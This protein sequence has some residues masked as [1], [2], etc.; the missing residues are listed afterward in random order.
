VLSGGSLRLA[1]TGSTM[2]TDVLEGHRAVPIESAT[3]TRADVVRIGELEVP[4]AQIIEALRKKHPRFEWPAPVNESDAAPLAAATADELPT[5]PVEAATTPQLTL[6]DC[7]V[8]GSATPQLKRVKLFQWLVFLVVFYWVRTVVYTACPG[9]MRKALVKRT[10]LNLVPGNLAW[11]LIVLPVHGLAFFRSFAA[12]P[13]SGLVEEIGGL[14]TT[15]R[16][17]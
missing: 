8:C 4:V 11:L 16:M 1:D 13:S 7:P 2:G 5:A 12:G 17:R 10:L 3:V 14:G 6:L 15:E 9:C